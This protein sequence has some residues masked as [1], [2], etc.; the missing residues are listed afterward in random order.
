MRLPGRIYA[1]TRPLIE[2]LKRVFAP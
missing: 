2:R 1:S